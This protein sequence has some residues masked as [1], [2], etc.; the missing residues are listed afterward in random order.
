MSSMLRASAIALLASTVLSASGPVAAEDAAAQWDKA[1][2]DLVANDDRPMGWAIDRWEELTNSPDLHF[3]EYA[4]FLVTY[5][6]FPAESRLRT[7]AE[8]RLEVEH[9]EAPRLVAYFDRFPPVTN[10][11]RA[12]YAL[13]LSALGRPEAAEAA[14]GAWRGGTMS[15]TAEATLLSLHGQDFTQAD[16]DARMDALLW[17]GDLGGAGRQLARTSQDKQFLFGARMLAL[18]D[19]DPRSFNSATDPGA[20]ADP[21]YLYNLVRYLRKSGRVQDAVDIAANHPKLASLPFDQAAWVDEMLTLARKGGAQEAERIAAKADEAFAPGADISAMGYSI[22]DDY[23]S[24]MWLGGTRALY[25]LGEPAKAAPLFYRYGAAARTPPTRSKGFYWAGLAEKRAGH[26]KDAQAYFEQAAQYPERFYG[27]LALEQLGQPMPGIAADTGVDPTPEQLAAFNAEPLTKAVREVARDAP[28]NVGIRFYREIAEQAQTKAQMQLVAD[29][30]KQIG[31]RDLA[32]IVGDAAGAKGFREFT[33]M[34][35]PTLVTPNVS[36]WTMVHAIAR[37]ESQFADNAIS[38]AG[39]KGLMQLMPGTAREQAGK[40]GIEFLSASLIDNPEYN[41]RLGDAYFARLM[42]RY[43]GSYPLAVAAYN[44]GVGNVRKWLAANG[45]PRNGDIGWVDWI[46]KIPIYETRNYVQRVLENAV[47]YSNMHP[48]K[49]P[50]VGPR[51]IS[52]FLGQ[53]PAG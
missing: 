43:Q 18:E 5:P 30:A 12:Q 49:A 20:M 19:S 42:D 35:Y 23:T 39:A 16:Q 29:L 14:R 25:D 33:G 27:Q 34:A 45:D 21:G 44:A 9:V 37:Q 3:S 46:E 50:P 26:D 40:I 47:V 13:A 52:Q 36:D 8:N 22:R 31:R 53:A 38:H 51:T 2:Q 41:I 24:L 11:G 15:P 6:G 28:W 10:A 17:Q 4:S 1:R 32:V 7:F 48:D